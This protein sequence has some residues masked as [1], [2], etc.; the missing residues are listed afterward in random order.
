MIKRTSRIA[1]ALVAML[2]LAGCNR[3]A[4]PATASSQP[5]ADASEAS[6]SEI[7]EPTADQRLAAL[8]EEVFER[9]VAQ[10]PEFQARLGRKGADYGKWDD[11]SEA[12]SLSEHEQVKADLARL[13]REI[14]FG[15]LSPQSQLSYRI[16]EYNQERSLRMFPWRH[17]QYAVSQMDNI[18][19]DL[20]T[21]LQNIH[22]IDTLDDA[23]AYISRLAGVEK[24]MQQ[25]VEQLRLGEEA[26]V[27]PP[28]MVYPR[29]LPAAENML[30]GAPFEETAEDGVLLGDFRAKL[31][32]LEMGEDD[33]AILVNDAANALSG[34]FRRGYQTFIAEMTRL[35]DASDH[36]D[37]V[38]ALPDGQAYYAAMV[39]YWTTVNRDPDEL[40]TL[41]LAEVARIR[42]EMEA[43]KTQ[44]G[45]DGDL[46][47]F[48]E[49][50]R[51]TPEN[52]YPNTDEGRAAYIAEATRLIDSLY[53]IAPDY[54]NVLPRAPLEVRRVE[55]W[56]EAGSSTA[57]YNRPAPD[58]SRPG[59]YYVN[60]QNMNAVQKHIMNSLAYHE[61]APGHH[62]QL[63]IQQELEGVPEFRKYGGYSAYSEGWA[64]YSERLAWE[65]GLYEGLP[66]R[67]FGRLAEEMKRAVRLVVDTGMHAKQWPLEQSIAYMTENTPMAPADIERQIK[68]YYVVP[69]QAL[70]Y[71]VGMLTILDLRDR[72]RRALGDDFDIRTFHD[73]VLKNG[74][75]PMA[76]LEKVVN[77]YIADAQAA[78]G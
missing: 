23:R 65:A 45:F 10:S 3:N 60:L 54:F 49:Y 56:R 30:E 32:A 25:V 34:P 71:K 66:M 19:G 77:D 11:Y 43:I 13:R 46:Q 26:G 59:I 75:M 55:P 18:A 15:A 8:L 29:V 9:N 48:F 78:S 67:D 22:R 52:Y 35:R 33:R 73:V 4:D 42:S 74:A 31:D 47:E 5:S 64:L 50:V 7:E 51:T 21:F 58:G 40:H 16:F 27:I 63:A 6:R 53:D 36:D 1:C 2:W 44:L 69:G 12:W 37:G 24:V 28:R 20:P 14:D 62:F 61:G 17:H 41:G 38:W 72:A 57:F 39:E 76:I 68:R 70:S